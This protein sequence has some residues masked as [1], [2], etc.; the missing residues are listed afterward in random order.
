MQSIWQET[1]QRPHF[2]TLKQDLKTDVAVIGG[3]IA[4]L[5]CAYELQAQNISVTLFEADTIC[6][7]RTALTTAKITAQHNAIYQHLPKDQGKAYYQASMQAIKRYEEIIQNEAIACD[8][9]HGDTYLYT[10]QH[11][12]ILQ[13]EYQAYQNL[14]IAGQLTQTTELPFPVTQA[15]LMRNQA[16]FHPL[17]FLYALAQRLTI[18]EHTAIDRVEGHFLKTRQGHLIEAKKIIFACHYPIINF[19][20]YYFLRMRQ[21]RSYVTAWQTDHPMLNGYLSIDDGTSFRSWQNIQ[22]IGGCPHPTGQ[23]LAFNPYQQLEALQ[24][25]FFPSYQPVQAW[26]NQDCITLDGIP[27]IGQYSRHTPDW[28]VITGFGKWG[29]T[30]A[31]YGA[32]LLARMISQ[33]HSQDPLFQPARFEAAVSFPPL[34]KHTKTTLTGLL[35]HLK[36]NWRLASSLALDEGAIVWLDHQKVAAYRDLQGNLHHCSCVC[37]HLGCQLHFNTTEKSWD[38]PCHGSRFDVDGHLINN[39]ARQDA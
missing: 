19:P 15:L 16:F 27:Y 28:Y 26:S 21:E 37:P 39:P 13:K 38:C 18:Y 12:E 31:L 2:P 34:L 1:T 32:G 6:N 22:L 30:Q 14:G 25:H 36:P 9:Y 23:D 7:G 3:G 5:L 20:G 35:S 8:F 11:P 33:G 17:K 10:Q 29:M 4:G 24:K